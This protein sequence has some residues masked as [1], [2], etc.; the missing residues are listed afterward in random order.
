MEWRAVKL[1]V[2]LMD[3]V[4]KVNDGPFRTLLY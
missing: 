1:W 2:A 4:I 3:V